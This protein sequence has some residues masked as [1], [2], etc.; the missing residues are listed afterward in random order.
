LCIILASCLYIEGSSRLALALVDPSPRAAVQSFFK[1]LKSGQYDAVYDNLPSQ[2]Q[3]QVTREQ[4]IQSLKRLESF[5]VMDKIEIGR[6]Q[7]RSEAAVVDT[8]IYGRLKRPMKIEGEDIVEGRVDVQ[9][10]LVKEGR[11]WR[12]ITADDRTRAFFLRRNP[13]FNRGFE[14]SAPRFAYKKQGSWHPL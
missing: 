8:T 3:Q 4:L 14:L 10:Y 5:L 11:D 6:V 12:V 9:Q 2:I 1:R 13:D 7:Q